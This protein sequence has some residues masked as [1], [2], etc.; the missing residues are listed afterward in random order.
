MDVH[1]PVAADDVK[2]WASNRNIRWYYGCHGDR[3]TRTPF[4]PSE[5]ASSVFDHFPDFSTAVLP[6]MLQL[7]SI[8]NLN[9][10][11]DS[12]W[13]RI[14]NTTYLLELE[15]NHRVSAL[16]CFWLQFPSYMSSR[17]RWPMSPR[18][19]DLQI[20]SLSQIG[21]FDKACTQDSKMILEWF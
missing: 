10:L 4:R 18:Q 3:V 11:R 9:M 14:R 1:P 5:F 19:N 21:M 17:Q 2:C 7:G 16:E 8:Q 15:H 13:M 20:W 6:A 12:C